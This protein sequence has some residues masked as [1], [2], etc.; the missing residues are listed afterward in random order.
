MTHQD[1][2][3]LTHPAKAAIRKYMLQLVGVPAIVLTAISFA[4][5]FFV[6]NA[7]EAAKKTG[8]VEAFKAQSDRIMDI[9][10]SAETSRANLEAASRK[11]LRF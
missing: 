2:E 4:A 11:Q 7:L 9:L 5:G 10:K 3:I 8:E 6:N 1:S